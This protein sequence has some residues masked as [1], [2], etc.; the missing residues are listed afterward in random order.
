M[1]SLALGDGGEADEQA[2]ASALQ[3][4]RPWLEKSSSSASMGGAREPGPPTAPFLAQLGEERTGG[5]SEES[6]SDTG[7]DPGTIK[8]KKDALNETRRQ[9][10]LLGE[11]GA[12]GKG[13]LGKAASCPLAGELGGTLQLHRADVHTEQE[14][15]VGELLDVEDFEARDKA[16]AIAELEVSDLQREI[17]ETEQ[18]ELTDTDCDIDCGTDTDTGDTDTADSRSEIGAASDITFTSR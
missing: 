16:I 11:C 3:P 4:S 14:G 13:R 18:A 15:K 2:A 7:T 8:K 10:A 1:P 5:V 17:T 6:L 12:E 9:A